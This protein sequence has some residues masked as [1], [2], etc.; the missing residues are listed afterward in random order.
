MKGKRGTP[1]RR[2]AILA[3]AAGV[4]LF[5]SGALGIRA[6][7][8]AEPAD[9]ARKPTN[10][11]DTILAGASPDSSLPFAVEL[12]FLV[13]RS[14]TET[15]GRRR[16]RLAF[17]VRAR[18]GS[19]PGGRVRLEFAVRTSTGHV[20]RGASAVDLG[21][22]SQRALDIA[23]PARIERVALRLVDP[24][25][26]AVGEAAA[27]PV[28]ADLDPLPG[29]EPAPAGT[30]ESPPIR[31]SLP[32]DPVLA[33]PRE[34]TAIVSL[35]GV[36]K[37][38]YL[39]DG[40]PVAEVA[41]PAWRV[42]VPFA[43]TP[44]PQTLRA[45]ALDSEGIELGRDVVRVDQP[46]S[47]PWL[48]LLAP[49]GP[50]GRRQTGAA[51]QVPAGRTLRALDL[52]AG[53]RLFALLKRPPFEVPLTPAQERSSFLRAVAVFD[54][55]SEVEDVRALLGGDGD[56]SPGSSPVEL[57]PRIRDAEGH[58]V[59][60]SPDDLEVDVGDRTL[61][62]RDVVPA[63]EL[64][65]VIGLAVD[66]SGSMRP[67]ANRLRA[68]ITD[69]MSGLRPFRDLVFVVKF[70]GESKLAQAPTSDPRRLEA[71]LR[72]STAK[73]ETALYDGVDHALVELGRRQARRALV[74]LSDG[75]D[76]SSHSREAET[77]ELARRLGVPIFAVA[78]YDSPESMI[79]SR[80]FASGARTLGRLA[81]STGGVVMGATGATDLPRAL[82][83][84]LEELRA[85]TL[86]MFEPVE[87]PGAKPGWRP[88]TRG[89]KRPGVRIEGAPGYW[90]GD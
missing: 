26:V 61:P 15:G 56:R 1:L 29:S 23:V 51:L 78:P 24:D 83:R 48:S 10:H 55:G 39:L 63:E 53:E 88:A 46:A 28:W 32:A 25:G 2:G 14:E 62:V 22:S 8:S 44:R 9:G 42:S 77:I 75:V 68:A 35:A 47:E 41:G 59:S 18:D 19:I 82:R 60:L 66:Q 7:S 54:D 37:V 20:E 74:L 40:R 5:L 30:G 58:P 81:R 50:E 49:Y 86:V 36:A 89:M 31:I 33:G 79:G 87:A 76:S 84:L 16:A 72:D 11:L 90:A 21:V 71:A 64:P 6:T 70:A 73:G 3:A 57:L 43:A 13:D 80:G 4:L 69:L 65:L 52:L 27:D 12:R 45:V 67:Y 38:R 85:E 34:V 17:R